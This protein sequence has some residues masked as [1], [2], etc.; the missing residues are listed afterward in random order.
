MMYTDRNAHFRLVNVGK[1][2]FTTKANTFIPSI[3]N[4]VKLNYFINS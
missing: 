2:I 4:K 3:L 1:W